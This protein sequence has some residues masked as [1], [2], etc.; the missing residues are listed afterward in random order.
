MEIKSKTNFID[1]FIESTRTFFIFLLRQFLIF[2][3]FL[4][5]YIG[6]IFLI[7]FELTLFFLIIDEGNPINILILI[8]FCCV[9]P[10]AI[11]LSFLF[12]ENIPFFDFLYIAFFDFINCFFLCFW[13]LGLFPLLVLMRFNYSNFSE[14]LIL[15]KLY[16][17]YIIFWINSFHYFNFFLHI[18]LSIFIYYFLILSNFYFSFFL[19]FFFILISF[20]FYNVFKNFLKF[21]N[22]QRAILTTFNL[23]HNRYRRTIYGLKLIAIIFFLI[24]K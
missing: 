16:V 2:Y 17:F 6:S 15:F 24:F 10:L 22:P 13:R 21:F 1:F 3:N 11:Y 12:Q 4:P 18:F 20:F 5:R 7:F 9:L 19:F 23:F 14:F 8:S